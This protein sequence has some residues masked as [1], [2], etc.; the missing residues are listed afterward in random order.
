MNEFYSQIAH[1]WALEIHRM[2]IYEDTYIYTNKHNIYIYIYTHKNT[3]IHKNINIHKNID[4]YI[5]I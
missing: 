1:C 3:D 5:T 4:I 2:N